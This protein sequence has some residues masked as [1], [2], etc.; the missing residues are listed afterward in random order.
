MENKNV[1]RFALLLSRKKIYIKEQLSKNVVKLMPR[2]KVNNTA[3]ISSSS[4]FLRAFE[5]LC[6][7][8]DRW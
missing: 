3:L 6:V 4:F 5:F 7:T 8:I 2:G 1:E